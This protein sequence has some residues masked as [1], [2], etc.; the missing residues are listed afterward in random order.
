MNPAREELRNAAVWV[1]DQDGNPLWPKHVEEVFIAL[2][3]ELGYE[4]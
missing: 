1:K 4:L 2:A 3:K